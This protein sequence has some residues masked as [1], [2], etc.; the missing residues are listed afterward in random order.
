MP[1]S[2]SATWPLI[3]L[4]KQHNHMYNGR[5]YIYF[6]Q[7][8]N[9]AI[10][11]T[12]KIQRGLLIVF[13][14]NGKILPGCMPP[15]RPKPWQCHRCW[16]ARSLYRDLKIQS[17]PVTCDSTW[18]PR[19]CEILCE[20]SFP[21]LYHSTRHRKLAKVLFK[22]KSPLSLAVQDNIQKN[23]KFSNYSCSHHGELPCSGDRTA[24]P[25]YKKRSQVSGTGVI[26]CI[27][28]YNQCTNIITFIN[29]TASHIL[30]RKSGFVLHSHRNTTLDHGQRTSP[31]VQCCTE[32]CFR[33]GRC[34]LW[35]NCTIKEPY[36]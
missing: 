36:T 11:T 26:T 18:S 31:A 20:Y 27:K 22:K 34:F 30:Q 12:L 25:L 19:H 15:Y 16:Q 23:D 5:L 4:P 29:T 3:Q 24:R 17:C 13:P 6:I 2:P 9:D 28:Q 33:T 1:Y 35:T 32:T 7:H 10:Y 21:I 8:K 14:E